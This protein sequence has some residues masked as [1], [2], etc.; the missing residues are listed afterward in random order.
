MNPSQ[1]DPYS[2]ASSYAFQLLSKRVDP[3]ALAAV[4]LTDTVLN[5]YETELRKLVQIA[6]VAGF[7][8]GIEK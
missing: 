6:W 8:K 3:V 4:G 1:T 5:Q 2:T 7:N